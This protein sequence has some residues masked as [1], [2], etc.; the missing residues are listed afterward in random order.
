MCYRIMLSALPKSHIHAPPLA[1]CLSLRATWPA[2]TLPQ[3]MKLPCSYPS[4]QLP[5]PGQAPQ[6]EEMPEGEPPSATLPSSQWQL[7]VESGTQ[8]VSAR[9]ACVERGDRAGRARVRVRI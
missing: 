2:V 8:H 9:V 1:V 5:P 4:S 3:L 6:D 7:L